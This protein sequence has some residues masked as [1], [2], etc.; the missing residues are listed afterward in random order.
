[1]YHYVIAP[2]VE[3]RK[4]PEKFSEVISQA[5]FS[6]Q[7]DVLEERE[8][9]LKIK[10]LIDGYQGWVKKE[11]VC[12]RKSLYLEK[13]TISLKVK[14]L[15]AHLYH[16]PDT[17]YGPILTLPF[18]SHL[19]AIDFKNDDSRWIKVLLP[20]NK[21][22]FIQRGDVTSDFSY[23]N[24][25]QMCHFSLSFQ[26][27]PY[28]WGGRSSFGYDCSGFVQMLYRQMGIFLPRDSK[29]QFTFS[30]LKQTSV[31]ALTPGNLVFF[32]SSKEQIQHVGLVLKGGV[33][34]HNSAVVENQPYIRISYLADPQWNGSGYYE[35]LMG[36]R[37]YNQL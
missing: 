13:G 24:L 4:L 37:L 31:E 19:E 23:M 6:E 17:I 36:S 26:G 27:I 33:F 28:T 15:S 20:D 25:D 10:T 2:T 30:D 11:G 14:R 34:I 16:T 1:M 7:V 3:M 22:G 12:S 35:F 29:D 21:E 9:C 8:N 5:L 18:E 32:G